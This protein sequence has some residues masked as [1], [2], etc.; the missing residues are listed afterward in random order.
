MQN[1]IKVTGILCLFA[2]VNGCHSQQNQS[3][4]VKDSAMTIQVMRLQN[5]P[6][7][8]QVYTY[9]ARLTP[10]KMLLAEKNQDVKNALFYQMDSCFYLE[11]GAKK[12]YAS[13][14]QP[15]ANGISGSFEYLLQFEKANNSDNNLSFIYQDKYF[16]HKKYSLKLSP[17]N[18]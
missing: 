14:V 15:V 13:L 8:D 3:L 11:S 17:N 10:Q 12:V 16:N 7:D 1:F 2:G 5:D 9:K 4:Q 18:L 6:S